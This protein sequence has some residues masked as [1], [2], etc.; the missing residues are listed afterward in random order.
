LPPNFRRLF[1][2]T[3]EQIRAAHLE[4]AETRGKEHGRRVLRRLQTSTRLAESY[5]WPGLAQVCRLTRITS[6]AGEEVTETAYA[7]TS[8]PRS[9]AR[10]ADLLR[11]WRGHWGIEN[12]SHYVR[13]VTFQEDACQIKKGQAPQNFAALRNALISLLRLQG[14]T[15]IAAALRDYTWK[16]SRLFTTFGILKQ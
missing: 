6:R 9:Q 16:S 14:C 15:N 4:V 11:W 12:R 2:P 13:D 8:V 3:N 7:I 10:A 1:P 5:D